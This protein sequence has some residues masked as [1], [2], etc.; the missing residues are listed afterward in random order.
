[1]AG[2]AKKNSVMPT[3]G[4][5]PLTTA[6]LGQ[7]CTLPHDRKS[8]WRWCAPPTTGNPPGGRCSFPHDRT[9]QQLL[10]A[11]VFVPPHTQGFLLTRQAHS[12]SQSANLLPKDSS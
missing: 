7:W 1:M 9:R 2:I 6:T 3:S 5:A 4:V 12:H 8:S 11:V 10:L